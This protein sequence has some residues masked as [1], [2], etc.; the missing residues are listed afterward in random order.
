MGSSSRPSVSNE[1]IAATYDRL[2]TLYDWVVSPLEART[3]QR[4]LELLA[5]DA[6]ERVLELGCGPGHALVSLARLVNQTGSVIGLD[7]APGMVERARGRTTRPEVGD[8]I[9]LLL[10]DARSLPIA[11]DAVDVVFIEDT[12]ELFSPEGIRTVLGE[13]DRVLDPDGRL[14]VVTMEREDAEHDPFVR[15]YEWVFERVPGVDRVGC[16]PIYARR[17]LEAD[18][19]TTEHRERLRRGHVWPVEILVGH[20]T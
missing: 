11:D 13:C 15:A 18:G 10:G 3:R 12:L 9:E 2:A 20:P 6:G 4:A 8:R 16:R 5:V 14:G 19:F 17:A 7:A 1:A